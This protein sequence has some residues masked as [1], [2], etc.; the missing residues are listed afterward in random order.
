MRRFVKLGASGVVGWIFWD[1]IVAWGVSRCSFAAQHCAVRNR[2][3][4]PM[5]SSAA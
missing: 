5:R 4:F 3:P 1:T 2:L